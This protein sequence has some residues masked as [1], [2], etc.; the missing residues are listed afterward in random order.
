MS[1]AVHPAGQRRSAPSQRVRRE[2]LRSALP[3][4]APSLLPAALASV[5]GMLCIVGVIMVGS[6]S[7]VVSIADYG[8][9]W[10]IEAREG[11]FVALGIVGFF[12][13][14][15]LSLNG[16]HR[17]AKL[18]MVATIGALV[19]VLTPGLGASSNGASRWLGLGPFVL[20]PSE[21]AK[22]AL[23]LYAA[24]LIARKERTETE[25][26]RVLVPLGVVTM[27]LAVLVLVQPDMGT[28]AILVA[29]A[30]AVA[31]V[32][33]APGRAL[34]AA[35][36]ALA[37]AAAV[38]GLALPYRRERLLSFL[39]P[40]AA[41]HGAGYQLLQ[42]KIGLGAGYYFGL[43]LGNSREKWGLLPNPHTDF[44]FAVLGEE[45]GL[46]GT[47]LVLVLLTT[48]VLLG[49]RVASQAPDRFSQLAAVG[50]AVWLGTE[51]IVNVGAVTGMLPITGIPL[52]FISFGGTSLV[53]DMAA[54]GI[55]VSIARRSALRPALRVVGNNHAGPSRGRT[56]NVEPRAGRRTD[57]GARAR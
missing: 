49:L 23:C 10:A 48:L 15:R 8:S 51:T 54:V 44:I 1:A 42:G 31:T 25:W 37:A 19:V 50:I 2:P 43:G 14:S 33:G 28:A 9:P 40:A 46:F 41:P 57:R 52:P 16:M 39:N 32:A 4:A 7:S 18:G 17:V 53:I 12:F 36:G 22:F 26:R 20:Q 55:L 35:L 34:G 30:F 6:A 45:L 38:A 27:A 3:L 21:L 47:V 29:I 11:L 5:L 13:A 56:R 24:H